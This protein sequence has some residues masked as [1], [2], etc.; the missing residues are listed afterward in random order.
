M[1]VLSSQVSN[2]IQVTTAQFPITLIPSS[3][4]WAPF[5]GFFPLSSLIQSTL[6]FNSPICSVY[7]DDYNHYCYYY[8]H[9]PGIRGVFLSYH[10]L[11]TTSLVIFSKHLVHFFHTSID[12]G[13][14]DS[15]LI[16]QVPFG[17]L[18]HYLSSC[19][20]N[21][22]SLLFTLFGKIT[23]SCPHFWHLTTFQSTPTTLL[24]L[25]KSLSFFHCISLKNANFSHLLCLNYG[26]L[27]QRKLHG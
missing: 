4:C 6:P 24:H 2:Q 9:L 8:L 23:Y 12:L 11:T 1:S 10:P 3:C 13:S 5:S 17:S 18:T 14:D 16:F 19:I 27:L 21:F 26:R 25:L 20:S 22:V 15:A 7:D